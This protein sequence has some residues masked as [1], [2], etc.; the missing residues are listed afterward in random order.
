MV[1]ENEVNKKWMKLLSSSKRWG[2]PDRWS[3]MWR[4]T[5]P[6]K[7]KWEIIWTGGLPQL[8]GVPY[9][10]VNRPY[11]MQRGVVQN[12]SELQQD[13]P[14]GDFNWGYQ[15]SWGRGWPL[16]LR[17]PGLSLTIAWHSISC[18][19]FKNI[20]SFEHCTLLEDFRNKKNEYHF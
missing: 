15:F 6:I 19:N 10:H 20:Y 3:N 4:L 2:T 1:F 7:L 18:E 5:P 16:T 12:T 8:P 11:I 9:L 17:P 14:I 13:S